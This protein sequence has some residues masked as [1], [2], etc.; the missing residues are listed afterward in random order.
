MNASHKTAPRH[1]LAFEQNVLQRIDFSSAAIPF[2][3]EAEIGAFIKRKNVPVAVNDQ[4]ISGWVRGI[5]R[6]ANNDHLLTSD[7]VDIV[8]EDA[9]VP[10][11]QLKNPALAG[12][13]GETEAWWFDNVKQNIEK[14]GSSQSRAIA[15]AIVLDVGD[16]A[17]SFHEDTRQY[18]QPLST[19]FRRLWTIE[20]KPTASGGKSISHN[21]A[22]ED[23]LTDRQVVENYS[24]LIFFR[25]PVPHNLSTRD[26]LGTASWRDEWLRGETTFWNDLEI[27]QSGRLG[28]PTAT[29]SQ[30]LRL[31]ERTVELA[32]NAEKMA[33]AHVDTGFISTQDIVDTVGRIRK[34]D[35]IFTK[36]F[37]ESTGARAAIITA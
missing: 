23:F 34:V 3:A 12:W 33:F 15:S 28:S 16:Y 24:G 22:P 26:F 2:S 17:L 14:L 36:D 27:V 10:G 13:F 29:K 8:L 1:W 37:S 18:R 35:T 5:A 21:L 25:L 30:Y 6:V 4:L 9:Y 20:P 7:E 19:I 32:S 11:Y 31:I